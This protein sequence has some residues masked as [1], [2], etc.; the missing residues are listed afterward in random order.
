MTAV[1]VVHVVRSCHGVFQVGRLQAAPRLR[2]IQSS[3]KHWVNELASVFLPLGLVP[4][5]R[6][7]SLDLTNS[8]QLSEHRRRTGRDN[9]VEPG[10]HEC[11]MVRVAATST[12]L[13][14]TFNDLE[15]FAKG[16]NNTSTK[17]G[18]A[19]KARQGR[20]PMKCLTNQLDLHLVV[21]NVIK[22]MWTI[23]LQE[24]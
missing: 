11:L 3:D 9:S 24:K 7:S 12:D 8:V 23:F 20:N 2:E 21:D 5:G 1:E 10:Q 4:R 13:T 22:V 17:C 15:L 6:P 16:A 14:M 18:D 19:H